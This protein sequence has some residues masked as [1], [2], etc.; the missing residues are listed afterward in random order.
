MHPDATQPVANTPAGE[1]SSAETF[2]ERWIGLDPHIVG[3]NAIA[4]AVRVRMEAC[5]ESDGEAFLAR[6]AHDA[7]QQRLFIDEVVVPESWFFRDPQVFDVLR[8]R[9]AAFAAPPARLRSASCA[10][11]APPAK[12]P[13]RWP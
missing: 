12:N 9:A 7:T 10:R 8:Q 3:S 6:L 1:R 4:H 11:P 5:G 13:I 2:L